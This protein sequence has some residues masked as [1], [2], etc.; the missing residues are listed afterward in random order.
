M[1]EDERGDL[2]CPNKVC[3]T[4]TTD[5]GLFTDAGINERGD[6]EQH[7]ENDNSMRI[8]SQVKKPEN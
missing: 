4:D 7:I 8:M 1:N 6:D 2:K 3:Q 5:G